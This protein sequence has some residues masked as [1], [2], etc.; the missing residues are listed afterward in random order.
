MVTGLNPHGENVL[1]LWRNVAET[2]NDQLDEWF[3]KQD[4][5]S[6]S[7]EFGLI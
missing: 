6:R 7:L 3:R 5:N 1:V 4:Y 2:G